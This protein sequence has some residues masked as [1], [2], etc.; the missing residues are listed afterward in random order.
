MYVYRIGVA[1]DFGQ[2]HFLHTPE[3]LP[4]GAFAIIHGVSPVAFSLI[5]QSKLTPIERSLVGLLPLESCP[6]E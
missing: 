3:L 4:E 2:S 5:D 6:E 1:E